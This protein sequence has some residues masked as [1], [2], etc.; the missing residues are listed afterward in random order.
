MTDH[1]I[2]HLA[3]VAARSSGATPLPDEWHGSAVTT[4][5]DLAPFTSEDLDEARSRLTRLRELWRLQLAGLTSEQLDDATGGGW[6]Q[7]QVA[8]HVAESSYYAESVGDL[9]GITP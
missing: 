9:S 5:A 2:D 7:R 1:L 3:E 6:T 8:F 4:P